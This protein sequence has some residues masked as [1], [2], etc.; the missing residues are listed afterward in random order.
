LLAVAV[1]TGLL[2]YESPHAYA[3]AQGMW[4]AAHEHGQAGAS[5]TDGALKDI[6]EAGVMYAARIFYY[7]ALMFA[8]GIMLLRLLIPKDGSGAEQ[9]SWLDKWSGPAMKALLVAVILYVFI[10]AA[11]VVGELGGGGELWLRVFTDTTAGQLW[12]ALIVLSVLGFSAL[13][14]PDPGKTLWAVLLLLTESLG[15]HAA[16]A[17]QAVVS[18]LSD[19]VHLVCAAVWAGG[20]MLLLLFWRADRKEVGRF[21]ERF[22]AVAWLT[23]VILT[24][25]GLLMTW[26]LIPSWLYLI[27]TDWGLWLLAKTVLVIGVTAIGAALRYRARRRELPRSIWLKLD[28][29]LMVFIVAIAAIF[30]VISPMPDGKPLNYH[31]MGEELHYTL[32]LSPNAPGPNE[33]SLT[34]WLPEEEG[35]PESV[36]L[37]LRYADKP[38][39]GIALE[40]SDSVGGIAF[41][42]FGEFRYKAEDVVLP[43]PG[44]W[45]AVI[46]VTQASGEK[47]EREFSFASN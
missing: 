7:L 13:K 35:E 33:A 8:A 21:A 36:S 32:K 9:R 22:S 30:T 20:V 16:A 42:G 46:T 18:V 39:I 10:H 11:R 28:G 29:L 2:L 19:F 25:S 12:L 3:E 31:Q 4:L 47:L 14:L 5:G 43:R 44:N 6:V 24:V 26:T 41:P 38:A 1:L 17:E 27:Y 37:S 15:G 45:T 34:V 23:I 40:A